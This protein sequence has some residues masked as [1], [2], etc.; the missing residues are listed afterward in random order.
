M[1]EKYTQEAINLILA[2]VRVE[3][4]DEGVRGE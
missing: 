3:M 4:E 2:G 1:V